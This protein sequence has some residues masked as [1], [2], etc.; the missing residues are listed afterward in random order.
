MEIEWKNL[1]AN[2]EPRDLTNLDFLIFMLLFFLLLHN[3]VFADYNVLSYCAIRLAMSRAAL[4][5]STV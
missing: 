2:R 3:E 4:E 1:S 5:K